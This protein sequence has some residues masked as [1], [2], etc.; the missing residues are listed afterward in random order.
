MLYIEEKQLLCQ[1]AEPALLPQT[2]RRQASGFSRISSKIPTKSHNS[3]R[4]PVLA[5]TIGQHRI[6]RLPECER[7]WRV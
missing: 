4:Q 5:F 1:I 6:P 3:S 7:R 2:I